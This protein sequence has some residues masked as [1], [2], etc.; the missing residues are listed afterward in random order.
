MRTHSACTDG[1][2]L[3]CRISAEIVACVE[4]L[5]HSINNGARDALTHKLR[6]LLHFL[7]YSSIVNYGVTDTAE[8][9]LKETITL[10]SILENEA[11][12]RKI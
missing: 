11:K 4:A 6:S 7:S 12:R 1:R 5:K 9:L 3:D 10:R 2:C 8:E